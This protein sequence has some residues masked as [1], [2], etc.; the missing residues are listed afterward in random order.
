MWSVMRTT[1]P[2]AGGYRHGETNRGDR[3]HSNIQQFSKSHTDLPENQ[4]W[5][6]SV[7]SSCARCSTYSGQALPLT[8]EWLK[9]YALSRWSPASQSHT[10]P[11][12]M[13][14]EV[15]TTIPQW[16]GIPCLVGLLCKQWR[17]ASLL[18]IPL[19][20]KYDSPEA[21][22]SSRSGPT[23]SDYE[24][25]NQT[26]FTGLTLIVN[27]VWFPLFVLS[28]YEHYLILRVLLSSVFAN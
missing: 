23:Q 18:P 7:E 3:T 8:L 1:T 12:D 28:V 22:I 17:A 14:N 11:D 4:N 5:S 2:D 15:P 20:R 9:A 27:S 6:S 10:V 26:A 24:W 16:V 19:E 25:V 13:L 21:P